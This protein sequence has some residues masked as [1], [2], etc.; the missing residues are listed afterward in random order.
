VRK[1]TR[2]TGGPSYPVVPANAGDPY[3]VISKMGRLLVT[4]FFARPHAVVMGPRVRG[5]DTIIVAV[6]RSLLHQ[7]TVRVRWTERLLAGDGGEDLVIVPRR[8]ALLGRL[9]L[10]QPEV[11][12]HQIVLAQLAVAGEEI[13]DRL[14]AHLGRGLERIVGAAVLDR[15]QI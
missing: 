6:M 8:L 3:R 9:H 13:L 7:R 2:M 14:L 11:V 5:D 4:T 10:H 15:L 12:H 1:V